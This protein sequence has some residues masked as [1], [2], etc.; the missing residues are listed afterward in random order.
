M[1]AKMNYSRNKQERKHKIMSYSIIALLLLFVICC[2]VGCKS[3]QPLVN[4]IETV[5]TEKEIIRDTV[6][7]TDPDSATVKALLECDSTNKVILRH[8]D[9]LQGERIKTSVEVKQN[10]DGSTNLIVECKED[11]LRHEIQIRDKIIEELKNS[12]EQVPVE[13]EKKGSAFLRNSGIA[14]WVIIALI[15]AGVVIGIILKFAK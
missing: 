8:I 14:L 1:I 13:V 10:T 12:R 7:S 2:F 6:I 4:M 11:S 9:L 3:Q 15:I 5:R